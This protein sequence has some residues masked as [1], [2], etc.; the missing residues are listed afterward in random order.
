MDMP[1][2]IIPAHRMS[3]WLMQTLQ[4]AQEYVEAPK[5]SMRVSIPPRR[6]ASHIV[7]VSSNCEPSNYLNEER[8][9]DLVKEYDVWLTMVDLMIAN[10][11]NL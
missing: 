6:Y 1:S 9:D 4:V 11:T 8:C 5:P 7:L 3:R 10:C 2:F